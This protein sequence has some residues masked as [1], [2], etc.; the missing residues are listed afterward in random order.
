MRYSGY[1]AR[2]ML[3][4]L[5]LFVWAFLILQ[6]IIINQNALAVLIFIGLLIAIGIVASAYRKN[7][8]KFQCNNC[9]HTF[10]VSYLKLLFTKVSR[11][12]PCPHK[13]CGLQLKM[14]ELQ[15][16]RLAY[17]IR[18]KTNRLNKSGS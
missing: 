13:N 3:L 7:F 4:I 1:T 6:F 5:T 15:Q 11:N 2:D 10:T 16:K 12:R 14:S 17:S 9:N 8:R 18:I